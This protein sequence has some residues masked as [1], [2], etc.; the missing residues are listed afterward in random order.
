MAV[1]SRSR[2]SR[3]PA[4]LRLAYSAPADQTV[5]EDIRRYT[6]PATKSL[7]F[8]KL[9]AHDQPLWRPESY[10]HVKSTGKRELDLHLGRKYAR[11]A[12]TAMK[13]DRNN[14]LIAQIVQDMM[15]DASNGTSKAGR[16]AMGAAVMRGFLAEIS[17]ALAGT[18]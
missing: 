17:E 12:I 10:W 7:P 1:K 16:N 18:S 14:Q 5:V 15:R 9:R 6:L 8:V 2:S 11:A 13:A 4:N 3:P